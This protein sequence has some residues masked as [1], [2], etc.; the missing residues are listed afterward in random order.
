MC[1][2][3]CV[4]CYNPFHRIVF[5]HY[6]GFFSFGMFIVNV[7]IICTSSRVVVVTVIANLHLLTVCDISQCL[8]FSSII[9]NM[10]NLTGI[11]METIFFCSQDLLL[12][13]NINAEDETSIPVN[14]IFVG[15]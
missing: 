6:I 7:T 10:T 11:P 8:P 9:A 15:S 12:I 13:F 1:V 14:Y 4:L 2:F 5:C 3:V